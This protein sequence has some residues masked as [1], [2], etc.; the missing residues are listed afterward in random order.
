[1]ALPSRCLARE[2]GGLCGPNFERPAG[3]NE[4]GRVVL[5]E[6]GRP[7]E[8]RTFG[9][10]GPLVDGE[11]APTRRA[12]DRASSGRCRGA[13]T[14][15]C[16][17]ARGLDGPDRSGAKRHELDILDGRVVAVR[18]SVGFVEGLLG[19]AERLPAG[20]ADPQGDGQLVRLAAVAHVDFEVDPP[21]RIR[22]A[23]RLEELTRPSFEL[24]ETLAQ[25][26][27]IDGMRWAEPGLPE[28]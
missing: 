13:A 7:V 11:L 25:L 6:N 10:D 28:V 24:P 12:V 15:R 22:K 8:V 5:L 21:R 16:P 23:G 27:R 20:G 1:R 9:E 26:V 3:R 18:G 4:H 19:L 17:P 14:V 2:D